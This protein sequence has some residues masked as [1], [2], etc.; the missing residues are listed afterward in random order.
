[1]PVRRPPT[2]LTTRL[3]FGLAALAAGLLFPLPGTRADEPDATKTGG[4]KYLLERV[5]DAAVVQLYADSFSSL[6]LKEKL[7]IWHL[8][9]AAIAGRDIYY[10]Q[11]CDLGLAIRDVLEAIIANPEGVNPKTLAEV[12]RYAK[13]FWINTGPYNHLTARKFVLKCTP[14]ALESALNIAFDN[15]AKL[16]TLPEDVGPQTAHEIVE[17]LRPMLFVPDYKPIVTNK[18]P[19][20]GKDILAESASNLYHGVRMEDLQGFKERYGLNSQL[21]KFPD[22]RIVESVYK[23]GGRY[24]ELIRRVVGHLEEA[25]KVAP[26]PTAKALDALIKWYTTGED[27]DRRAY[28]IAWVKDKDATV[29][30]IN[31]FIEVYMDPRG[32][33]GSWESAVFFVNKEKTGAIKKLAGEATW[34]EAHMPWE[35]KYRKPDVQGI[36]ANAIEVVVETGDCGPVTPIGINLPNDQSVREQFGSKSVSLSN[37]IEAGDKAT[38]TAFRKEFSWSDEE[39]ARAEKWSTLANELLVNMH[40]VIG[41]ASG[42]VAETLKGKPQDSL[43]EYYSALEEGRADLVALYY[44]AD[45]KL[46]DLGLIDAKDQ[47]EMARAAYEG[48]ARNALVQLR[49]VREGD[50]LEEDHMRNRQMVVHWLLANTRA[51]ETRHRDGKTYH[52]V[53]DPDGFREGVGKLLSEVQRIKSEGDYPAAKALFESQGVH[54]DPRRRDEVV[55]RVARLDLPSYTAFVMPRLKPVKAADGTITDVE[56]S[57]PMDLTTEMLEFSAMSR[58]H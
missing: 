26:E 10:D 58:G 42:R 29:D 52:V 53:T 23:V 32:I 9:Q 13:L 18:N 4:R 14:R 54:F 17:T 30:T 39:A 20:P 40:E 21:V 37:V 46:A 38:P 1:M 45:P 12:R 41:H 27:A 49:R 48:Y 56:I 43:K 44:M 31:G 5:D 8:Y 7:L 2:A 24:D 55:A 16:H 47:P 34:F 57:Y 11:R 3:I 22:G 15:G 25:K 6:P 36:T 28:D 50:Q 19:G 33:K 51:I 35:A